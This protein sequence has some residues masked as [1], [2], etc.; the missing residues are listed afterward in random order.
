MA[1]TALHEMVCAFVAGCMDK[2]NYIQFKEFFDTGGEL[3]RDEM[4]ELQNIISLVPVILE[5]ETPDPKL[6]DQVAKTLKGMQ[7]EIKAQIKD[8]TKVPTDKAVDRI[9]ENH[10]N[11]SVITKEEIEADKVVKES[12][13]KVTEEKPSEK[14][15]P[16]TEADAFKKTSYSSKPVI[17][18]PD[19]RKRNKKKEVIKKYNES[20]RSN[21][22]V[23]LAFLFLLL[24][25][26]VA[27][28][29]V[30]KK[31]IKLEDN[32]KRLNQDVETLK[33]DIEK[34]NQFIGNHRA[35]IDFFNYKDITVTRLI[36]SEIYPEG[37]GKLL[38]SFDEKEAL[39][40]V[41]NLPALQAEETY[42]L[43][44]ISKGRSYSLGT[45]IPAEGEKYIRIQEF[46]YLPKEEIELFRITNE[47]INGS[48]LPQ[49][50][51]FLFG[52][53]QENP[54]RKRR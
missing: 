27:G 49:G 42:Q 53:L 17:L 14:I 43:W 37:S 1:D 44:L 22:G 40:Q 7:D 41:N 47:P 34:T 19:R 46:P 23:W 21:A 9:L 5:L 4:G 16:P 15:I 25:L 32:I 12:L 38:I 10:A 51:T 13:K 28:Y 11:N 31:S 52:A 30:Y 35:L 39:L 18:P 24:A 26:V 20:E 8:K 48:E 36:G 45:F 33:T 2:A 54:Q 29:Y 3:P 50:Q 6:K